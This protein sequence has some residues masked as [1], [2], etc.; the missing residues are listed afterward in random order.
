MDAEAAPL[1]ALPCDDHERWHA[2]E[3]AFGVWPASAKE[4]SAAMAKYHTAVPE[5][6]PAHHKAPHDEHFAELKGLNL[7]LEM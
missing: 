1:L 2:F 6:A 4:L 7:M 3:K 5:G